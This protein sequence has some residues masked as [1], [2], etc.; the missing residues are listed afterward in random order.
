MLGRREVDKQLLSGQKS[1]L[2]GKQCGCKFVCC[3]FRADF[4]DLGGLKLS[5]VHVSLTMVSE[6]IE[7]SN[8]A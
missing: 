8:F 5:A 2:S 3:G 7:Q 4:T 6:V 1:S